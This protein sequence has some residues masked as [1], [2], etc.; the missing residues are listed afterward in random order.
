MSE[1]TKPGT[2]VLDRI[3]GHLEGSNTYGNS[4]LFWGGFIIVV[5]VLAGFPYIT[6][7]YTVIQT[8]Q[9]F[10]LAFLGLSLCFIWGYAGI[11]SFGQVVF[12]GIAA[13]TFGIIGL[14]FGSTTGVMIAL[15]G[16]IF[17]GTTSA[18]LLGYFMFYGGVRD[19]YVTIMT[20]V[21]A[22]VL[23]TFMTQ[24]AGSEWAVG[25]AQLGGYNGMDVPSLTFGIG[26]NGIIL[27]RLPLYYTLLG[28]LVVTYIG[29]RLL[30]NSRFGMMMIAIRED[31]TR[32]ET[33]GYNIRFIKLAV[34]TIGGALAALSGVF[35]ASRANFVD[36][37]VFGIT[38]AA[39]PVVWVAVGGRD[40]LIGAIGATLLIERMRTLLSSGIGPVGSEWALVIVG[41]LLLGVT[42][43]MPDGVI[44]TFDRVID[45]IKAKR[46]DSDQS[47]PPTEE[48]IE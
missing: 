12:F 36:P 5:A 21:I 23:E 6:N 19:T 24:T 38:F 7:L 17:V 9:Y 3:R 42:L 15:V 33:F 26:Q 43:Y 39:L 16:A 34:F 2:S 13:Y 8:S 10:A 41:S 47:S 4:L 45:Q 18:A 28:A 14:N 44:P 40:S 30:V 31:E 37:S 25:K 46:A 32:T 27:E 35:Y 1:I 29:L 20:L 11:L 48:V 22:L